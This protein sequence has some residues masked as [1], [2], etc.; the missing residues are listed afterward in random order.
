MSAHHRPSLN[1]ARKRAR[2]RSL[3]ARDGSWCAY[4][5]LLFA[6]LR[7]AT[8]DHVVP[9]S[10]YRTWRAEHTVLACRPCN[11]AKA[12]RLPL[13]LALLLLDHHGGPDADPDRSADPTTA[14]VGC[15][16]RADSGVHD[17]HG[18]VFTADVCAVLAFIAGAVESGTWA[19]R[20]ADRPHEQSRADQRERRPVRGP[21]ESVNTPVNGTVHNLFAVRTHRPYAQVAQRMPAGPY[22][23]LE[24]A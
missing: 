20:S 14:G 4:C 7:N 22:A 24:A 10:L 21:V 3:A 18:P 8:I 17:E 23:G 11:D 9:V 1:A 15:G 2:K 5:G 16:E 12:D 6:D 19:D 13:L